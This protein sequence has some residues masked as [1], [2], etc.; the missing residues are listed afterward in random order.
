MDTPLMFTMDPVADGIAY[1]PGG[2]ITVPNAPGLGARFG[3]DLFIEQDG[4][5]GP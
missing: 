2:S 1:G 3:P 4:P 5:V